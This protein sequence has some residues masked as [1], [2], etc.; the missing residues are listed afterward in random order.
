MEPIVIDDTLVKIAVGLVLPA[1]T[2]LAT[3]WN[4]SATVKQVVAIVL[5]A[6]SAVIIENTVEDGSA[7]LSSEVLLDAAILYGVQILSYLGIYKPHEANARLAPSF[8]VG[9]GSASQVNDVEA[10]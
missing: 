1:L 4:A 3:K 6:V 7:V 5:A 8:G 2:G 10:P 9:G